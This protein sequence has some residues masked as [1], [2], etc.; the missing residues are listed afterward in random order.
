MPWGGEGRERDGILAASVS[1]INE[2]PGRSKCS[3]FGPVGRVEMSSSFIYQA[4]AFNDCV[5]FTFDTQSNNKWIT[6]SLFESSIAFSQECRNRN[7]RTI[8]HSQTISGCRSHNS[9][10]L[11]FLLFLTRHHNRTTIEIDLEDKK[12][13]SIQAHCRHCIIQAHCRHCITTRR[14]VT[15]EQ[16]SSSST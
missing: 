14:H 16:S 1:L 4:P 8:A 11:Q 7:S 12:H 3:T 9:V 13:R 2:R 15:D 5:P 10:F 6:D